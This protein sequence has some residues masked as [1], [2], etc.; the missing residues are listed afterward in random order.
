MVFFAATLL[1]CGSDLRG[2]REEAECAAL[3]RPTLA[4][5]DP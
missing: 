4:A 5:S 3:F 2:E 1:S